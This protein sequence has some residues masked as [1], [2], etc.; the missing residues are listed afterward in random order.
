MA[1]DDDF[2]RRGDIIRPRWGSW[3]RPKIARESAGSSVMSV[4]GK[5]MPANVKRLPHGGGVFRMTGEAVARTYANGDEIPKFRFLASEM[6]AASRLRRNDP[7][8]R[9]LEALRLAFTPTHPKQTNA[10]FAGRRREAAQI[11]SAIDELRSH[12]ILYGER[13]SGKT[14]LA[15][16]VMDVARDCGV[17]VL[18]ATCNSNITF[19]ELFAG[20]LKALFNGEFNAAG[21]DTAGRRPPPGR[22]PVITS[23]RMGAKDVADALERFQDGHV[24]LRIDEFDRVTD[25]EMQ[26]EIAET[27]KC[28]SDASAK[29]TLL[30]VGVGENLDDLVGQHPSIQ[31][32]VTGVHLGLMP[33]EE[34]YQLVKTGGDQAGLN[35]PDQTVEEIVQISLGSPYHA[36]LV[37]LYAGQCAIDRNSSVVELSD[38]QIAVGRI[39]DGPLSPARRMFDNFATWFDREVNTAV[40][41][42]AACAKSDSYGYFTAADVML[43]IDGHGDTV[44]NE[45]DVLNELSAMSE[46]EYALLRRRRS[47][48]TDRFVFTNPQTRFFIRCAARVHAE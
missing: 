44:L 45:R 11:V 32:N 17:T 3:G 48:H 34:I 31:R 42:G 28:L 14:S 25:P 20:F 37:C 2:T 21:R 47:L 46:G 5:K 13:G 4:E 35:F 36:Q 9:A 7:R 29:V 24:I 18:R 40:I 39:I 16:V 15:N 8:A 22:A 23:E 1:Q 27:I 30:I 10:L 12:V 19:H 6:S 33:S 38:L 43:E 41:T 26:N